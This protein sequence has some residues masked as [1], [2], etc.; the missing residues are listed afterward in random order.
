M[1]ENIWPSKKKEEPPKPAGPSFEELVAVLPPDEQNELRGLQHLPEE[2]ST[3]EL[4]DGLEIELD[5]L[6]QKEIE[7]YGRYGELMG[8][9]QDLFAQKEGKK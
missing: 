4:E 1:F 9:A 6:S 2:L 5:H 8:K 3:T 7:L